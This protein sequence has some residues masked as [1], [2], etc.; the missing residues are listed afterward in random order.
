M[1]WII[2]GGNQDMRKFFIKKS[3]V[4]V[5]ILVLL[6]ASILSIKGDKSYSVKNMVLNDKNDMS[7][8]FTNLNWGWA[9]NAG[10]SDD[11]WDGGIDTDI[12]GNCYVT[13]DFQNTIFFGDNLLVSKGDYDVFVSKIDENGNWLWSKSAGGNK[14]DWCGGIS[15][16]SNGN[17]YITGVF[18][19]TIYF[20]NK[21]LTSSG[22]Y[23]VFV[24]KLNSN[25]YWEWVI[26]IKGNFE[27][28]DGG[29][30]VDSVGNSYITGCFSGTASFNDTYLSSQGDYDIYIAKLDTY[31][32]FLWVKSAGGKE[33][34]WTCDIAV[35]S[36]GNS[37]VTGFYNEKAFFGNNILTSSGMGEI[38]VVKIDDDGNWQWVKSVGGTHWDKGFGVCVDNNGYCYITGIFQKNVFFGGTLLSSSGGYDI[39][40]SKLDMSGNWVWANKAGGSVEEGIDIC[41]DLDGNPYVTGFF[42]STVSFGEKYIASNGY[43]DIFL[44]KLNTYGSWEWIKQAGGNLEDHGTS[45]CVD[46]NGNPYV[47]GFFKGSVLF[48]DTTLI[49]NGGAD[50]FIAKSTPYGG[51]QRYLEITGLC[52]IDINVVD[53]EGRNINKTNNNIPKATYKEIDLDND[54]FLDDQIYI[55]DAI[56]GLYKIYVYPEQEAKPTDTFSIYATYKGIRYCLAENI[57]IMDIPTD[58]Y[59]L[60][61]PNKPLTPEGPIRGSPGTNYTYNTSTLDVDGDLIYYMF[62]WDDGSELVWIGPFESGQTI[63][64][65]HKWYK[66]IIPWFYDI[67]VKS[68]DIHGFE[69]IWS[70]SLEINIPRDKI[71]KDNSF[72]D[73]FSRFS[74]L[75]QIIRILL[76]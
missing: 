60:S 68:R 66:R 18:Q 44:A 29:I 4:F 48:G 22:G 17:S 5:I 35:D 39:F 33:E 65:N 51:N 40:V 31:G 26:Q 20:D 24:A 58:P 49:R 12:E 47:T 3:L 32:N 23:D 28:W 52:P 59:I 8:N 69:S 14:G 7:L 75:F 74:D 37:Y 36:D 43:C 72:H 21:V 41:V 54:G 19:G 25:V 38:F 34:E 2:L 57:T 11:D 61:W 42:R 62:D 10:G 13:G 53:T 27:S 76:L 9:K 45:V 30:E 64:V 46:I 55:E 50:F 63:E 1:S 73:L 67:R 16:D 70:D 15:V 6:G 71:L 56:D